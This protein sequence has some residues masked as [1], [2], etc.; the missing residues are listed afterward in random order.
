MLSGHIGA[1]HS[2]AFSPND[3]KVVTSSAD[4]TAVVWDVS[5]GEELNMLSGDTGPSSRPRSTRARAG[6][7]LT[8]S[9]DRT[10]RIWAAASEEA[11][12]TLRIG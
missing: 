12:D 9:Y 6:A 11:E 2:G 5:T 10:A 3:S 8:A 4:G 7:V 1:V